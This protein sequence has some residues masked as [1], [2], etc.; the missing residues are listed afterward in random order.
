MIDFLKNELGLTK[1]AVVAD[2]GSGTGIL[3]KLF[4]DEGNPVFGVEPNE[5]MRAAAEDLLVDYPNFT[6][7]IGSAE[8]TTLP[9]DVADFVVAGQAFHWFEPV[10]ARAELARILKPG[11]YVLLIWNTR[12]ESSPFIQAFNELSERHIAE[13]RT[14]YQENVRAEALPVF[15]SPGG[16]QLKTFDNY[17]LFNFEEMKGRALS[18]SYAPLP[19]H[20]NHDAFFVGLSRLFTQYQKDG[21]VEFPYDTQIFYGQVDS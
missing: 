17:Q 8:A 3:T 9:D 15:F 2:I 4:L 13:F 21:Q 19:G 11:G 6:S 18:S 5:E 14:V 20:P 1:A 7:V 16:Y 10:R 12:R